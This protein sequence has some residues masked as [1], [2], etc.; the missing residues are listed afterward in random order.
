MKIRLIKDYILLYLKFKMY[1]ENKMYLGLTEF[2][3]ET[4][5]VFFSTLGIS[6]NIHWV[7]YFSNIR[8]VE[9]LGKLY[10]PNDIAQVA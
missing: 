7:Q 9:K 3:T 8:N 6:E 1:S 5:I 10:I 4:Y 2:W